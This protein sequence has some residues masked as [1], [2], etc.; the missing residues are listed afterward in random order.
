MQISLILLNLLNPF[1]APR[2]NPAQFFLQNHYYLLINN[3]N[4][5]KKVAQ[6]LPQTYLTG[7]ASLVILG[8]L[9][10]LADLLMIYIRVYIFVK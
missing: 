9:G 1:I 7:L 4:F 5:V 2:V 10:R 6:G 3:N 8:F